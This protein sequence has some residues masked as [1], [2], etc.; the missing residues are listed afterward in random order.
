MS[1]YYYYYN[2]NNKNLG[3]IVALE[4]GGIRIFTRPT[5]R[6]ME[7]RDEGVSKIIPGA[8]VVDRG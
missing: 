3:F 1:V 6:E 8:L 7:S 5:Q 4:E 2:A